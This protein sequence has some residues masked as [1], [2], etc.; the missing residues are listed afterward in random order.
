MYRC[1]FAAIAIAVL[2]IACSKSPERPLDPHIPRG[3]SVV[4]SASDTMK[5][6]S[7]GRLSLEIDGEGLAI[8]SLTASADRGG[9]PPLIQLDV[10]D[11]LS[12]ESEPPT[13][14]DV[15]QMLQITVE[16]PAS[17]TL[18]AVK[19]RF[20]VPQDWLA[21]NGHEPDAVTLERYSDGWERLPTEPVGFE[22]D[23]AL[24]EAE[25]PGFSLFA[26]TA[27]EP[28]A[29][30]T[31]RP[32]SPG[33]TATPVSAP[34]PIPPPTQIPIAQLRPTASV[35]PSVA[36]L[37]NP[38]VE[39]SPTVSVA[40]TQTP[41]STPSATPMRRDTPT[42]TP[43]PTRTPNP[44]PTFRPTAIPVLSPVTSPVP[45]PVLTSTPGIPPLPTPTPTQSPT[46]TPSATL[47]PAPTFAPTPTPTSPPTPTATP[48]SE[49][50]PV[51][52]NVIVFLPTSTFTA[53]P[54]VTSTPVPTP[55]PTITPTPTQTNTPSPTPT[56]TATPV[57][58]TGDDRFGVVMHSNAKDDIRYFL[59][60]LGV[61]WYLDF[62]HEMA[63]V[64]ATANK[65][66]YVAMPTDPTVWTSGQ[67]QAIGTMT[68]S[69]IVAL[70][71]RDPVN[72]RSTAI[73]Y[74]GSY[75]YIF[76]EANRY[77]FMTGE[78]FAPVFRYYVNQIKLADDTAKI[79]GTSILNWDWTCFGCPGLF[80]CEGIM[81]T[82]YQCGKAWLKSFVNA[83][84]TAY[85]GK[86]PV[87]VWAIDAYPLDWVRTPN[88]SIHAQIVIDQL[89]G[90]RGYLDTIRQYADTPIWIT[91]VAVHVGY[92]GW[93]IGE[94]GR[95]EPVGDYRAEKM[96]EYL[97]TVLD[98]LGANWSARNIE[99]WFFFATWKNI[100]KIEN[101]GYMGIIL[102]EEPARGATLTCLGEIYRARALGAI[103]LVCDIAGNAAPAQ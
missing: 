42:T 67:A 9:S 85:G 93:K 1:T 47:T 35:T 65:V 57:P 94:N 92:D 78:R 29:A 61:K 10:L 66:P 82:G 81:L 89:V 19:L 68:N 48:S 49:P 38:T 80:D 27:G 79:I 17:G 12:T 58:L 98:W 64:P 41:L 26:I 25:S 45:T 62:N 91:E 21:E 101:D 60:E 86:P 6:T 74:P 88:S 55:T 77:D 30:A 46:P 95:L 69:Q 31:P 75:W 102:F 33:L 73:A 43:A 54:T 84:E 16:A 59:E 28:A 23:N 51:P 5:E 71:F 100:T 2:T 39:P 22:G 53:T 52:T 13:A 20:E 44:S 103:P 36:P 99:K 32:Q 70:G 56:P 96:S 37:V 72:I 24:F 7:D 18:S 50:A 76:G 34:G 87:D 14:D 90:M 8:R 3:M 97:T 15:Y 4:A 83:Y 11:G 40:P 63:N